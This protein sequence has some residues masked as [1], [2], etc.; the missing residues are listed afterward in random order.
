MANKKSPR[1]D[2]FLLCYR[3]KFYPSDELGAVRGDEVNTV[4]KVLLNSLR[5][6]ILHQTSSRLQKK[7]QVLE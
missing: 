6:L 3:I 5:C 1:A 7:L 4:L 2:S